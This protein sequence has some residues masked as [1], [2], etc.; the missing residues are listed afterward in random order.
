MIPEPRS[1]HPY[2]QGHAASVYRGTLEDNR[3]PADTQAHLE[4]NDGFRAHQRADLDY[5]RKQER[6]PELE[7]VL[8][9]ISGDRF[10]KR[11]RR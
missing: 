5:W 1:P 2:W 6:Q 9:E 8:I 4:W 3:Y 10:K 7:D 11:K